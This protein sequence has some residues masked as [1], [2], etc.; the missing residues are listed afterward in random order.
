[1]KKFTSKSRLIAGVNPA[2]CIKTL[3]MVVTIWIGN[4]QHAHA[5]CTPQPIAPNIGLSNFS[6]CKGTTVT[7]SVTSIFLP[8]ANWIATIVY[9]GG[10][11]Q[12]SGNGSYSIPANSSGNVSVF[13]QNNVN[14]CPATYT[15]NV[16]A[17]TVLPGNKVTAQSDTLINFCPGDNK[18]LFVTSP[19]P[20]S[21]FQW[22]K[23]GVVVGTNNDSLFLN[24]MV[25]ADTGT[26]KCYISSSTCPTDSS[27]SIKL[28]LGSIIA[29]SVNLNLCVG[30]QG[31]LWVNAPSANGFVWKFNGAAIPSSNND[32][33]VIANYTAT[34]AGTYTCEA[35]TNG[36]CLSTATFSVATNTNV[37]TFDFTGIIA[38]YPMLNNANN[39]AA[40]GNNGTVGAGCTLVADRNGNAN[41]AY[42]FNGAANGTINMGDISAMNGAGQLSVTG[43]FK[44]API[45]TNEFYSKVI[46]SAGL[47][48]RDYNGNN[49]TYNTFGNNSSGL[50]VGNIGANWFHYAM[51]FNGGNM[52]IYINGVLQTQFTN[53]AKPTIQSTAGSNFVL[54]DILGAGTA[55]FPST[56]Y[57]GQMDEINIFNRDLLAA[58]VLNLMNAPHFLQHPSNITLCAGN[59]FTLS[60][61]AESSNATFQ[62]KLNGANIAGANAATYTKNNAQIADAGTYTCEIA[63]GCNRSISKAATVTVTS[64]STTITAQPQ[65]QSKCVG[66]SV[67]FSI[68]ATGGTGFQWRKNGVAVSGQTNATLNIVSVTVADTGTYSCDVLGGSCGTLS[69]TGAYLSV[70][71]VPVASIYGV[72]SVCAGSSIALTATGGDTYEWSN[73][74]GQNATANFT[75]TQTTTY[76]VTVSIGANCTA[77]ATQ[78][79]IVKQPTASS[80]S[81]AVCN[82]DSYVFDNQTLTQ[83][84]IYTKLEVNSE[85]CDSTITLNLSVLNPISTTLNESICTG[86]SYN[87]NGQQLSQAGQYTAT[88]ASQQGCDSVVTLNLSIIAAPQISQQPVASQTQVCAGESVTLTTAASGA[89]LSYQWKEGNSNVGTN[90]SSYTAS[91]LTAGTKTYTVEVSNSCGSETSNAVMVTVNALPNPTISQS[92]F[93]LST[94]TFAGY[95][96]QLNGNDI[97]G[98]ENQN[99]TATQNGNYTVQ[100]TDANGCSNTSAAVDVVGVGMDD[101]RLNDVRF[102]MYPVPTTYVLN[103]ECEEPVESIT[104]TDVVGR[105][106]VSVKNMTTNNTQLATELL[107]QATYFIHIKTTT[108]KTAVKSFVKQ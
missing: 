15:S 17:M 41:S 27:K 19:D 82:G 10:F 104:I 34:Q 86:S 108:G 4:I 23:N 35:T 101:V 58:D 91:N 97:N 28:R 60:V 37:S 25:A 46:D 32:T 14:N 77:T 69:S 105:T 12:I 11:Q 102:T 1:M 6:P 70:S 98:A 63:V 8:N 42:S 24:S 72:N 2:I 64:N 30:S 16:L 29:Q 74:G 103:I 92:G 87:F 78:T 21:T 96:W 83:S 18:F 45:L 26:Y 62:W 100:V 89:N 53:A 94:Q 54:G 49:F 36:S 75:A 7:V 57:V 52:K 79:V 73:G 90:V 80:F 55:P 31:I 67:T 51:T 44:R 88:Y 85:G 43:W 56:N 95:Q 50:P 93:D 39:A 107:A 106:L 68:S 22:R 9:P 59:S 47:F 99:Y 3:L 5:Q 66:Q 65:T 48:C 81:I 13:I 84:G 33:L 71:L 20:A 76:T 61:Q 38:S 40:T